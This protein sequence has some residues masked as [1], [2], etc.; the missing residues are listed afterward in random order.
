MIVC[1]LHKIRHFSLQQNSSWPSMK[2]SGALTMLLGALKLSCTVIDAK[3]DVDCTDS[4]RVCAWSNCPLCFLLFWQTWSHRKNKA[5]EYQAHH[6]LQQNM[7]STF[8]AARLDRVWHH[9]KTQFLLPFHVVKSFLLQL[10]AF[11][12]L[13]PQFF[14]E[15]CHPKRVKI[16]ERACK[17]KPV[18]CF[19]CAPFWLK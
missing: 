13:L 19:S 11:R 16:C 2:T 9:F 8:F 14:P 17:I 6:S 4:N 15:L 1:L 7:T 10:L 18:M 3:K 5:L 12:Q